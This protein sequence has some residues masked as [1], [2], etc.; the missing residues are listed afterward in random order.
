M[1]WFELT[2]IVLGPGG[3]V[4]IAMRYALN[5]MRKDIYEVKRDLRDVRDFT[6][7]CE[8]KLDGLSN[9]V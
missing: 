4:F 7:R 1:E 3:G 6:V 8:E 2:A 5:G 9:T